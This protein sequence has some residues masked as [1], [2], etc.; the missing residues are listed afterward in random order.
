MF[1]SFFFSVD[2]CVLLVVGREREREKHMCVSARKDEQSE[3]ENETDGVTLYM[4]ERR[5][6]ENEKKEVL[7]SCVFLDSFPVCV[8]TTRKEE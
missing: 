8:G 5:R 4:R 2:M 7:T 1:L 6:K 3:R